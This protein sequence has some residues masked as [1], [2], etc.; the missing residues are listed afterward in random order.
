[1]INKGL[2]ALVALSC[3]AM[4]C[5]EHDGRYGGGETPA[6]DY[7]QGTAVK[8][9][10]IDYRPAPGQFVNTVPE[11]EDGDDCTTMNAKATEL[12]ND[13]YM[14]SLGAWGGNVTLR[15]SQPIINHTDKNDFRIVGN[16]VYASTSV[17]GVRYG[18]A[19]PGIVLVMQDKNGNGLPDD[20]W[21]EIVGSETYNST[22][23][24]A[25]TYYA[26]KADATDRE[27]IHWKAQNGDMGYLNRTAA[28]HTQNYFPQWIENT[29][30]MSF[31]G[32][33]LPPNGRYNAETGNYELV[34]YY[35]YADS[36]PNNTDYSCLD[37]ALAV[38]NA[39][40][41][42]D[43]PSIDFI[44]IYT[45]V[46]QTNGHLGECSTEIAGVEKLDY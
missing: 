42:V 27:Y 26:P 45:G 11:Y 46:L 15:L 39:G 8:V 24:Y 28:Y 16:A 31:E 43:L 21:C 18:S 29:D 6:P 5:S 10:V 13:G 19:E 14:I 34:S 40:N 36:H 41:K 35:G 33:L 1:M 2:I 7:Q 32:R 25:V 30:S 22:A 12:L 9:T 4:A 20:G 37:I 3:V 23:R 38:D 44:K 17:S